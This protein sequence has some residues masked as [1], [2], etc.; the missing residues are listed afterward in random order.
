MRNIAFL[1]ELSLDWISVRTTIR[2]S[3]IQCLAVGSPTNKSLTIRETLVM[4]TIGASIEPSDNLDVL[5]CFH[6]ASCVVL[7]HHFSPFFLRYLA[8]SSCK[9]VHVQL[10][11]KNALWRV[12]S[13]DERSNNI[14]NH[15]KVWS[16][17]LTQKTSILLLDHDHDALFLNH[18]NIGRPGK[19]PSRNYEAAVIG[20]SS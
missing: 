13:K 12:S 9:I 19:I 16:S 18:F 8:L 10:E 6:Y 5:F 17:K 7:W 14:R 11:P 15:L 3:W 2:P 1:S 20:C 4:C